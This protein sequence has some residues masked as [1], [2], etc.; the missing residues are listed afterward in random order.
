MVKNKKHSKKVYIIV[1][2]ALIL[3][4]V[5]VFFVINQQ[6]DESTVV[7]GK[8]GGINLNPPT[9]ADEQRVNDTKKAIVDRQNE[10]NDVKTPDG[11]KVVTPTITDAGQYNSNVEV[12]SYVSGVFEDGGTCTATFINGT[13]NFTKYVTGIENVSSVTC[14]TISVPLSQFLPKGT[15]S[16][17]IEYSSSTSAG[18]SATKQ[19]EVN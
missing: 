14:P 18:K 6:K 11:K 12:S 7:P 8:Q 16:V 5:A 19:F 17:S 15:W 4:G 2:I 9:K 1:L 3:L 13:K 10:N